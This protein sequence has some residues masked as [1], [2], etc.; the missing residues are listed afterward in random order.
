MESPRGDKKVAVIDRLGE[1][2]SRIEFYIVLGAIV[3]S[4]RVAPLV[5]AVLWP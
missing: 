1:P 4:G 3:G 2:V 5:A